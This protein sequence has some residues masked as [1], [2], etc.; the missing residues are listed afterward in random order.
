VVVAATPSGTNFRLFLGEVAGNPALVW[1]DG[2]NLYYRRATSPG[3]DTA[4]EWSDPIAVIDASGFADGP[5]SLA[6][7][8]GNP[9]VAYYNDFTGRIH[10]KR[11]QN[12]TGALIGDWPVGSV[13][14]S[15]AGSS[16]N[17]QCKLLE[18]NGRPA[19]CFPDNFT[20]ALA[21]MRAQDADGINWPPDTVDIGA[22]F[23]DTPSYPDMQLVNGLPAVA[24]HDYYPVSSTW[25]CM[26]EDADGSSWGDPVPI[27][28]DSSADAGDY[29]NLLVNDGRPTAIYRVA[30]T[31]AIEIA[32]ARY[33]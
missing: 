22:F 8:N 7:I 20:G 28:L 25:F 12:T 27:N 13:Q 14:V 30:N 17:P 1:C 9:A 2:L 19:I 15:P 18:V 26:A 5:P 4:G 11:A 31:D 21:Y 3:G 23:G 16:P 10:Y 6:I 32:L 24:Y 29:L 33:E